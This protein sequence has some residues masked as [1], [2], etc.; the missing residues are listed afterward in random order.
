M[1][2]I[3]AITAPWSL[4]K[5]DCLDYVA[6]YTHGALD[7]PAAMLNQ[8]RDQVQLIPNQKRHPRIVH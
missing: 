8:R 1:L 6:Q 3:M 5:Y 4:D 2:M 7:S